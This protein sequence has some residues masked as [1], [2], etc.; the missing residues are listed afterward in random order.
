VN[1]LSGP[2][3]YDRVE[4]VRGTLQQVAMESRTVQLRSA[5]GFD[6]EGC[7]RS[8]LSPLNQCVKRPRPCLWEVTE[9]ESVM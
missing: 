6:A 8:P 1:Q 4:K 2:A 3:R 7:D 5:S 9:L